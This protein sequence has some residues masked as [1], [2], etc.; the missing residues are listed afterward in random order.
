MKKKKKTRLDIVRASRERAMPEVKKLVKK[1][2]RTAIGW[3]VNQ[4]REYERRVKK[5]AEAKR[6]VARLQKDL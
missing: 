6:E 2:G 3:C 4:L 1:Y 5:L